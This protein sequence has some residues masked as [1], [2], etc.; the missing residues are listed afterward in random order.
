V[1]AQSPQEVLEAVRR[2]EADLATIRS[3]AR[4]RERD[5][6]DVRRAI[7]EDAAR[8]RQALVEDME[9]LV[10]LI[11][12]SWR[13]THDQIAALSGEITGLRDTV[14]AMRGA[15]EQGAAGVREEVADL[16]RFAERTA[17]GLRNARVELHLGPAPAHVSVSTSENGVGTPG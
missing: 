12:T 1:N 3:R 11:G 8:E 14:E 5:L 15:T 9:R 7:A 16:R 4:E 2:L 6:D 17:S 13:A 10:D